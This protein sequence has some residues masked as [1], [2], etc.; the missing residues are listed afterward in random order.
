MTKTAI[1]VEGQTELIFVREFLLKKFDYQNINLNCY[2]LFT[3]SKF[4]PTEHEF[5][6]PNA[7][8]YF[9]IINIGNDKKVLKSILKRE[10]YLFNSGFTKIIGLRDM[11][12]KQYREIVKYSSIDPE[13]N[14][15]FI[16]SHNEQILKLENSENIHFHF[17]IMEIE[18]WLLG[19]RE[20]LTKVDS[21]L[22]N[23]FIKEQLSIDLNEVDPE[24]TF[25]RPA[26]KLNA[27][28][29]L[30]GK[31]YGK[32]KSDVNSIVSLIKKEDYIDLKE[33]PVC[34]SFT[35][36]CDSIGL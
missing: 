15:K 22:T 23:D 16:A 10:K 20:L 35:A 34:Q 14:Q 1:F 19:I 30:V 32:S 4:I 3:D 25:F 5:V 26:K 29:D 21:K 7:E 17:A 24:T 12:S 13:V 11:Y 2:T 27:I 31:S 9:Q 6:S 28:F 18:S 8:S 33:S 36:F